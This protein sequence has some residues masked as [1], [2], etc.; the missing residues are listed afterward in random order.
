MTPYTILK[1]F[2]LVF[3]FLFLLTACGG[4]DDNPAAP[5]NAAPTATNVVI[6]G[7][8]NDSAT[9]GT[10]LSGSYKYNDTEGD[11][12]DVPKSTFRWLREG[13][14]I[15]G[16]TTKEYILVDADVGKAIK[17]EVTPVAKA[18][19]KTGISYG[20][21]KSVSVTVAT[22]GSNPAPVNPAPVN[23]AP[24]NPTPVNPTPVNPT[25]VNPTPVNP[26]PV[27]PTPVNPAPTNTAPTVNPY[28]TLTTTGAITAKITK[29]NAGDT[30]IANDG[31]KDIDGDLI[32]PSK[33]IYIWM[34][35][36]TVLTNE[37]NPAQHTMAATD[38]S[39]TVKVTAQSLPANN[40][41]ITTA[42]KTSA[43]PVVLAAIVANNVAPV[44][45]TDATTGATGPLNSVLGTKTAIPGNKLKG[46]YTVTDADTNPVDT[47]GPHTFQ[48]YYLEN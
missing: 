18:G 11:E 19:T 13:S 33:T 3:S 28:I 29:A 41:N 47:L 37:N 32:D 16:A 17:F 1:Y 24:V 20:T 9:V 12:E 35:G 5:T 44:A 6:T 23:P 34:D 4:G 7:A 42:T 36:T 26:T 43:P 2:F 8:T 15:D 46:I 27:N 40:A 30:L 38:T 45:T 25:P 48:W 31:Y 10:A 21:D 39:I 14:A 22:G